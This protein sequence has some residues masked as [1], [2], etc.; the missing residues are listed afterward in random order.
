MPRGPVLLAHSWALLSF[1]MGAV[2]VGQ[3][4]ARYTADVDLRSV[5]SGNIGATNV[6]RV[7]GRRAGLLTLVADVSKGALPVLGAAVLHPSL[8]YTWVCGLLA[9]F[10]HCFTPFLR[11]RGGKGVATSLGV[12]G[13]ILPWVALG[14]VVVWLAT[15]A[16]S[17]RSSLGAL[18]ALPA[19]VGLT[20][21]TAPAS[22]GWTILLAGLILVRHADNIQRLR[23]GRE[24]GLSAEE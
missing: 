19:V 15:V 10:G 13:T 8:H 1:V 5:G 2:P 22:V 9:V 6:A 23:A 4:V 3:I 20:A 14:G 21:W 16:V 7:V 18:L 11:W 24:L 12:L 17:R